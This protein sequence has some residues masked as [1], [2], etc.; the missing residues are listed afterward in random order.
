ML[1][2][3]QNGW[4]RICIGNWTSQCDCD[5]DVPFALLEALTNICESN[6]PAAVRFCAA[7]KDAVLVF[8]FDIVHIISQTADGYTLTS[9]HIPCYELAAELISD[10]RNNLDAWSQWSPLL[11]DAE[12]L[13]ARK[14]ELERQCSALEQLVDFYRD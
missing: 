1:D 9:E 6:Q 3:P 12:L 8:D 11:R 4:S 7:D 14:A 10:L 5:D 2:I 13:A